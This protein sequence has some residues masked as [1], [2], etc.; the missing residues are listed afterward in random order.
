ML[1][2]LRT[3]P[4][5]ILVTGSRGKSSLTRLVH[6]AFCAAGLKAR[7]RITGVLPR[8]L[9]PEGTGRVIRRTSPAHIGEMRWWLEQLPPHTEALVVENSAV[10]P[11]LQAMAASWIQPTL[12]VWTT[13]RPDHTEAWGP[14]LEGAAKALIRGVPE[15]GLVAAGGEVD[16]PA[17]AELFRRNGNTVHFDYPPAGSTHQKVNLSLAIMAVSLCLPW[18]DMTGLRAVLAALPPDIADFRIIRRGEDSLASAFS[19][20]D[21]ESTEKLFEETGWNAETTTLLYHHRPDRGARLHAFLPWIAA[22]QWKETVFTRSGPRFPLPCGRGPHWEDR[23]DGADGFLRW[24]PGRG[25]V[26]ACGN[27]SGWPLTFLLEQAAL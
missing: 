6:A 4:F 17:L 18:A 16:R 8:E 23:L 27:V 10:A 26:F 5:R 13:L 25:Q 1:N 2:K 21:P 24:W 7:G 3:I 11:D 20:N 14:G 9:G 15:G 22:R 12:T 19:A